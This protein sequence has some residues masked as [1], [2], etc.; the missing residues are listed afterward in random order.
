MH[1]Y[2]GS[3][4][5]MTVINM[6]QQRKCFG[7]LTVLNMRQ[8]RKCFGYLKSR[9]LHWK[10]SF[11]VKGRLNLRHISFSFGYKDI[12]YPLVGQVRFHEK[13]SKFSSVTQNH[14]LLAKVSVDTLEKECVKLVHVTNS[15]LICG[16]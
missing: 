11:K 13:F 16:N 12:P 3:V 1:G 8:Q 15:Y 10:K 4:V 14:D 9:C 6:L 5:L 7:Y 2:R